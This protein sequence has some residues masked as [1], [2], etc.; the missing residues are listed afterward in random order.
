MTLPIQKLTT[1]HRIP[2]ELIDDARTPPTPMTSQQYDAYRKQRNAQAAAEWQHLYEAFAGS[3]AVQAV[4][5]LHQPEDDPYG[6]VCTHPV[7]GYEADAQEW[8]CPT[9]TAIKETTNE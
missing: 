5:E 1:T 7:D 9:Y 6:L 8:P 3:R 4:L 2:I